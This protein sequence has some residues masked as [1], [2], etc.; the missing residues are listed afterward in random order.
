ML[1]PTNQPLSTGGDAPIQGT[2]KMSPDLSQEQQVSGKAVLV[3]LKGLYQVP[4]TAPVASVPTDCILSS[5]LGMVQMKPKDFAA[6]TA[7]FPVCFFLP[8]FL[9]PL[10]KGQDLAY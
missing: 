5:L 4:L 3:S 7:Y 9:F 1:S 2:Q 6:S 8:T 10:S